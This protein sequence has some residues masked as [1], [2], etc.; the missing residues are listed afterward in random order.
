MG[1]TVQASGDRHRRP[2]ARPT[3]LHRAARATVGIGAAALL[4]AVVGCGGGAEDQ[5]AATTTSTTR[6]A[7]AS[8][9][10]ATASA[11]SES[12]SSTSSSSTS[13]SSVARSSASST[14]SRT[15]EP[16]ATATS[17]SGGTASTAGT[18]ASAGITDAGTGKGWEPSSALPADFVVTS[19]DPT[20]DELNAIVHFLVATQAS[21]EAKARNLEAGESAVVVPQTVYRLGL[22][23]SP[24]GWKRLSGPI[25][26]SDGVRTVTLDASSTGRPSVHMQID[27]VYL[28]GNWRL[29]DSSICQGVRAVG[30]PLHCNA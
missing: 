14:A 18:A 25:I 2:A 21:D 11:S 17:A 20:L 16:A 6:T 5:T 24:N 9:S 28:D 22:F 1:R 4:F 3:A 7:A 26:A 23:R 10:S 13:A 19:E 15:S 30:L 27:F 29:A 12:S 8:S